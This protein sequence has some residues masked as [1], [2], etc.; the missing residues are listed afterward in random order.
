MQVSPATNT[1]ST[2]LIFLG[3]RLGKIFCLQNAHKV[4]RTLPIIFLNYNIKQK[5]ILMRMLRWLTSS[6]LFFRAVA[7]QVFSTMRSLT[8]VFGMRTGGP[9]L[10]R[11][12]LWYNNISFSKSQWYY[13]NILNIAYLK[14]EDR[15][16]GNIQT[17]TSS[18]TTT[19]LE[20]SKNG[21]IKQF[22]FSN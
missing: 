5:S 1:Y 19:H 2:W 17:E 22:E 11:H 16:G 18:L 8:S 12:R 9:S 20:G 6:V 4:C 10:Y 3:R 13:H 14:K 7:S 21:N 15:I